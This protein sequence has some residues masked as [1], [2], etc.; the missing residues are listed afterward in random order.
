MHP[1]LLVFDIDQTDGDSLP[2]E[3]ETFTKFEGDW[4]PNYKTRLIKN[5]EGFKIRVDEKQ[6]SSTRAGFATIARGAGSWKMRIAIH[7]GLDD[8]SQFGA[9][10]HELAHV[11]LGH[12][13][14][15]YDHWWPARTRLRR[16]AIE[17]EAEAVAWLVTNRL[18]LEGSSATYISR[19]LRDGKTPVGVSLDMIAKTASLIERMSTS[20]LRP[21]K[22]RKRKDAV[23]NDRSATIRTPGL[24][25]GELGR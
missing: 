7:R 13:G 21:K 3:L 5:A 23:S 19:H 25:R 17:V 4:D 16:N 11:L 24:R 6:L 22:P 1:V 12:L 8:P 18:G 15:D 10:C 2:E 20:K 14:S 9:L